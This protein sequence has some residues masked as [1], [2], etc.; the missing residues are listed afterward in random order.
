MNKFWV[1]CKQVIRKNIKSPTYIVLL[2][3]PIIF[4]AG[5]MSIAVLKNHTAS[6]PQIAIVANNP[7]LQTALQK[8]DA[9]GDYK[10]NSAI[11]TKAA[12][13]R[14]LANSRL[15]GYLNVT[16]KGHS[17]SA[18][19]KSRTNGNVLDTTTLKNTVNTLKC[20]KLQTALAST[21]NNS[22]T[23]LRQLSFPQKPSPMLT[24]NSRHKKTINS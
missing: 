8:S 21:Q 14:A 24:V 20:N 7:Q 13:E 18:V 10:V 16:L 15:D 17:V 1:V 9:S 12:A 23:F 3:M 5:F 2:L 11:T 19:Y 22:P 4:L 6:T